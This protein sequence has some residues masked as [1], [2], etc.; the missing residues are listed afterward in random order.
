MTWGFGKPWLPKT[1]QQT[2]ADESRS[3]RKVGMSSSPLRFHALCLLLYLI[4]GCPTQLAA[5]GSADFCNP[6][7]RKINTTKSQRHV[8]PA[9]HTRCTQN[10]TPFDCSVTTVCV[11][12][13]HVLISTRSP[14]PKLLSRHYAGSGF[15]HA[16]DVHY[17]ARYLRGNAFFDSVGIISP[18]RFQI[19]KPRVKKT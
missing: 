14:L 1:Q 11:G 3:M 7:T 13:M 17:G 5:E 19:P 2:A 12:H 16:S 4:R 10:A 15:T 8:P 18:L 9:A 6:P